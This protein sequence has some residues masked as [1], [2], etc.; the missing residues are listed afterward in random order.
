MMMMMM[1]MMMIV[2]PVSLCVSL[3]VMNKKN[4][5]NNLMLFKKSDTD[6]PPYDD[7]DERF[8]T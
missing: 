5:K 8:E 6:F 7:K 4:K 2:C 3:D 1:M